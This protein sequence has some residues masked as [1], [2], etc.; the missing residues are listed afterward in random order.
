MNVSTIKKYINKQKKIFHI[1]L[2]KTSTLFF[3]FI[4][5]IS[6]SSC[7]NF[8]SSLFSFNHHFLSFFLSF[9]F[10][11][12]LI[13]LSPFFF[14]LSIILFPHHPITIIFLSFNSFT[15]SFLIS[16]FILPH[17]PLT[18]HAIISSIVYCP[19]IDLI[20]YNTHSRC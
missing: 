4:F 8:F 2:I 20:L 6:L 19:R 3:I 17:R 13:L 16:I 15:I 9:Y 12:F 14:F 7:P 1:L 5:F 18:V 10:S 11:Y